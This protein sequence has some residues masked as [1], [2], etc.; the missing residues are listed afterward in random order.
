MRKKRNL[1]AVYS[2][3]ITQTKEQTGAVYGTKL[4]DKGFIA[5]L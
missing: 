1:T 2:G 4:A 5:R 3:R